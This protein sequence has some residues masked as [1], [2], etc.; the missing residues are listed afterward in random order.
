MKALGQLYLDNNTGITDAGLIDLKGLAGT[1]LYILGISN[2]QVTGTGL[3][4]LQ[5]W[6]AGRDYQVGLQ[7]NHSV[8]TLEVHK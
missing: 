8:V 2:T 5:K 3:E 7:I 6:R 4:N 1:R